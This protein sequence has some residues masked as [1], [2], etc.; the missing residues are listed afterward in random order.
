M[1]YEPKTWRLQAGKFFKP[2]LRDVHMS[3]AIYV[4]VQGRN[5]DPPVKSA[6]SKRPLEAQVN[7]AIK[8]FQEGTPAVRILNTK[9]ML[10]LC[11]NSYILTIDMTSQAW[12]QP[13]FRR[14]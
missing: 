4:R 9:G 7:A 1:C 5:E 3:L 10:K 8:H 11:L 14:C 2:S 13:C 6:A 12:R